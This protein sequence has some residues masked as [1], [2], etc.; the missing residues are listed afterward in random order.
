MFCIVLVQE[1]PPFCVTDVNLTQSFWNCSGSVYK[2][3]AHSSALHNGASMVPC[4]KHFLQ[5]GITI[6]TE[7]VAFQFSGQRTGTKGWKILYHSNLMLLLFA[8]EIKTKAPSLT[9]TTHSPV[10]AQTNKQHWGY[11]SNFKVWFLLMVI[12]SSPCSFDW[13]GDVESM[14]LII[15][16]WEVGLS[17]NRHVSPL[18]AIREKSDCHH[19]QLEVL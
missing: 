7:N 2:L 1:V 12:F 8:S 14:K 5:E 6:L 4:V 3:K 15:F 16:R 18:T 13:M 19:H 11:L 17:F 9:C 10:T